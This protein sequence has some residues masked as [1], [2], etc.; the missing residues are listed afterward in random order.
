MCQQS[1]TYDRV[2]KYRYRSPQIN[3]HTLKGGE[4]GP[5]PWSSV[6]PKAQPLGRPE[7][8]ASD[9]MTSTCPILRAST[10]SLTADGSVIFVPL[11]AFASTTLSNR[12]SE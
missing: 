6:G 3:Q 2:W 5:E 8:H 12:V 1:V 7:S 9:S 4:N 11:P 10:Q